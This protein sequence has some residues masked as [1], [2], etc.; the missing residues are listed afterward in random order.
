[1]T[2]AHARR[3]DPETS[4]AAAASIGDLRERQ[5]AVLKV[6]R[7]RPAAGFTDEELVDLYNGYARMW[8]SRSDVYPPQSPSGI[9]TRRSELVRLGFV[10]WSGER[11]VMT[12]GRLARVWCVVK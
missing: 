11:R 10:E 5:Y 9:R 3:T 6:L 7:K 8:Q 12:T 2:V 4:R 1:M